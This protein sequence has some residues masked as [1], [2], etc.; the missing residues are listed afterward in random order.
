[1]S[2]KTWIR[3]WI[4]PQP[5]ANNLPGN[6]MEYM[7]GTG[8]YSGMV[9][10][11]TAAMNISAVYCAV[12]LI[13]DSV[14][15]MPLI[16][17]ERDEDGK[18]RA[19][20][21]PV[22]TLLKRRPNQYTTPSRFK[23]Q[24]QLWSSLWGNGFA[25]IERTNG[26][27][28]AGL[29]LIHPS[30][31]KP[32]KQKNGAIRWK[33]IND[34]ATFTYIDDIDMLHIMGPSTDGVVGMSVVSRARDSFGLAASAELYGRRFFSNSAIP[35]G[36]IEYPG[37]LKDQARANLRR[38]WETMH[39]GENQ[40]KVAILEEGIKYQNIGMPSKDAQFLET[41]QFQVVEI[42]RWFNIPPHKLKDLSRATF[43]NIEE[44]NIDYVQD[45]IMPLA[46]DFEEEC[47]RKL[48]SED[49]Q[50]QYFFEFLVDGLLRS[51]MAARYAAYAV[52]RQWGWLSSN[53]VRRKENMNTLEGDQGDI[54][55][56][57][58]N[59][60]PADL[61]DDMV[62][63][64]TTGNASTFTPQNPPTPPDDGNGGKAD[65]EE[66]PDANTPEIEKIAQAFIPVF[67]DVYG[68]MLTK[69]SKAAERAAKNENTFSAWVEK[70]Y[71]DHELLVRD[72]LIP[73]C[74]ACAAAVAST[75][76]VSLTPEQVADSTKALAAIHCRQSKHA[77]KTEAE[78]NI[79][80]TRA[81]DEAHVAV[82]EFLSMVTA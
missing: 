72:A 64:Q 31:V 12:N 24:M 82:N 9:T 15:S 28:P 5:A 77:L 26:G 40:G 4:A 14:K 51:N 80:G 49:E 32:E 61:V 55:L 65:T 36:V 45:S 70:F 76:G 17:Y 29:W 56:V 52:G 21:H 79:D 67:E 8:P 27:K 18:E 11:E 68:R 1:M 20:G 43:S 62:D 71:T 39:A 57:P 81:A 13:S 44:Q 78:V 54:Y 50:D 73:A 59:M 25:E 41:R 34:N 48:L 74:E 19:E 46:I 6:W 3:N 47:N 38:S 2:L 42:A 58:M 30:R 23:K 37:T 75:A 7:S 63:S 33:V 16:L 53:D 10:S 35:S 22:Y 66:E 60:M 69:E